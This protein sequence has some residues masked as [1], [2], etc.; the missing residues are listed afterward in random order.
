MLKEWIDRQVDTEEKVPNKVS[1]PTAKKG[2]HKNLLNTLF[3]YYA[4]VL[5][6]QK[7]LRQKILKIPFLLHKKDLRML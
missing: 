6:K 5:V 2:L 7:K 1:H 4:L 3:Q